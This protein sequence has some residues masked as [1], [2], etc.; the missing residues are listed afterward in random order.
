ME[1]IIEIPDRI[2]RTI[3]KRHLNIIDKE[4]VE[5]AIRNGIQLPKGHG[6]LIDADAFERR[7]MFDSIVEDKQDVIYA[8]R[9]YKPTI[10]ADKAESEE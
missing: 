9:Y 5:G 6:R 10:E 8:L 2:Y 4:I 3:Q 7:C 1:L